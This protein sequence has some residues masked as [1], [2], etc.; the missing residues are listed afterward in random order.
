MGGSTDVATARVFER[1]DVSAGPVELVALTKSC[2]AKEPD[3]RPASAT[4]VA[5]G[6]TGYLAGV[7]EKLRKLELE[8]ASAE[9]KA[10][11][12]RKK[13]RW[14]L[15]LV[16][17]VMLFLTGGVGVGLWYKLDREQRAVNRAL[18]VRDRDLIAQMGR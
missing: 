14:Q 16:A 4:Q 17:M 8:R 5:E 6:V 7:Q 13:R 9:A 1:L 2:L 12:E 11:E 10:Q 18:E 15:G 3:A